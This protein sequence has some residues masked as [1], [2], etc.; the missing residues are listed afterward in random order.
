MLYIEAGMS[1]HHDKLA[2]RVVELE[3]ETKRKTDEYDALAS[4][5]SELKSRYEETKTDNEKLK[6]VRP[7]DPSLLNFFIDSEDTFSLSVSLSL[8]ICKRGAYAI[9]RM[10][11]CERGDFEITK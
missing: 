3:T 6:S 2:E 10:S 8:R 7:C 1:V 4:A 9:C 11:M 5:H